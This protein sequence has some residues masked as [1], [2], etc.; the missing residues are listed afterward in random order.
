L[1]GSVSELVR[2]SKHGDKKAAEEL[3]LRMEPLIFKTIKARFFDSRDR[4]DMIQQGYLIVLECIRAYDE[5]KNELYPGY[6]KKALYYGLFQRP[7]IEEVQCLN[8]ELEDGIELID[9]IEDI[10]ADA[11]EE[12][13]RNNECLCLKEAVKMLP[14]KQRYI[15][16]ERFFKSRELKDIAADRGISYSCVIKQQ[17]RAMTNLRKFL[18]GGGK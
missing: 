14:E 10:Q 18:T 4:E 7:K 11:A 5:S 17:A 16:T 9:L 6:L 12:A 8:S 13:I 15:I 1:Y 2:L 3:L